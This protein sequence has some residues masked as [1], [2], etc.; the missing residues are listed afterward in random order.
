MTAAP[1]TGPH[2]EGLSNQ[3]AVDSNPSDG[4][5]Q[6]LSEVVKNQTKRKGPCPH[7]DKLG[8]PQNA[9]VKS[10][11]LHSPE[12]L[13]NRTVSV[14]APRGVSTRDGH[15]THRLAARRDELGC[16]SRVV[17]QGVGRP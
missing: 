11:F 16:L 12:R 10:Q 8:N 3:T 6:Q 4:N 9:A 5:K 17:R 7:E 13:I 2:N 1:P 15:V 14:G